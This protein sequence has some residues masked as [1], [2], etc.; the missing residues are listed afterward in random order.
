VGLNAQSWFETDPQS[1]GPGI[2]GAAIGQLAAFNEFGDID[3]SDP[4]I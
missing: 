3:F 2:D 1:A 4:A